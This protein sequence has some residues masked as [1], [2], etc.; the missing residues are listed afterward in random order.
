MVE[1]E[2]RLSR[3]KL[4]V[5]EITGVVSAI[6]FGAGIEYIGLTIDVESVCCAGACHV[7]RLLGVGSK[8]CVFH[9]CVSPGGIVVSLSTVKIDSSVRCHSGCYTVGIAEE[10][11]GIICPVTDSVF[12][13]AEY[14]HFAVTFK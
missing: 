14:G 6:Y 10:M 13:K 12:G 8:E 3:C 4:F 2:N 7:P 9:T 1:L 5:A 11:V